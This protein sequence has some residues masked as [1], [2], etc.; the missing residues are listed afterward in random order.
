MAL[1]F[2]RRGAIVVLCDIDEAGN[3]QTAEL[4]CKRNRH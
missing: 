4:I 1:L 2:A 3:A